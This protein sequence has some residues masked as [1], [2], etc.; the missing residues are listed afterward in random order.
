MAFQLLGYIIEKRAGKPFS[1]VLQ[2]QILTPL[3]MTETTIFAPSN[4]SRGIIPVNKEASGWSSQHP[5][6]EA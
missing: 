5:S 1:E 2:Q 4:S 3:K 6:N